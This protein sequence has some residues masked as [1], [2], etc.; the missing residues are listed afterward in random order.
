MLKEWEWVRE[1]KTVMSY[2]DME[3]C[4]QDVIRFR[5]TINLQHTSPQ[6]VLNVQ[7]WLVYVATDDSDAPFLHRKSFRANIANT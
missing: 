4:F 1:R 7:R 2:R 3:S 5:T 6:Q